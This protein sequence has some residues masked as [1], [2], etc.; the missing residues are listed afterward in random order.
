MYSLHKTNVAA[1]G[2]VR[3]GLST[4]LLSSSEIKQRITQSSRSAASRD[5]YV[6]ELV[7]TIINRFSNIEFLVLNLINTEDPQKLEEIVETIRFNTNTF[8]EDIADL[9]E[10]VPQLKELSG[11][12]EK[13]LD[14]L[15]SDKGI[16][17]GYFDNRQLEARL[18]SNLL[19]TS[20]LITD[21]DVA[22]SKIRQFGQQNMVDANEQLDTTIIYSSTATVIIVI[23]AMILT[24]V[25]SLFLARMIKSPLRV[26]LAKLDQM[27]RGDYGAP[28]SNEF[29]G[30][31]SEL[32]TSLNKLID[33]MRKIISDLTLAAKEMSQVSKSNQDGT[34][35]VKDRINAQNIQLSSGATAITQMEAAIAQVSQNMAHSLELTNSVDLDVERGQQMM[36]E[37]LST[38]NALDMKMG[39]SKNTV[40]EVSKMAPEMSSI[41]QVIDNVASKTNLL[42]LNAAIE[43]ARAGE[44]GRGFAVVAD[45]VRQL[46]LLTATS[47]E[48]IR[49]MIERLNESTLIASTSMEASYEQ[50]DNCKAITNKASTEMDSIRQNISA[51]KNNAQQIN[52][53]IVEQASTASVISKSV[54]K[55]NYVSDEN[56]QQ[57][58]VISDNSKLINHQMTVLEQIIK[59]FSIN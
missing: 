21:S 59:Q 48:K 50:L 27:V 39:E 13:F 30:E 2:E 15:V 18:Q 8:N 47:T 40:R 3:E 44:H 41:I 23:G 43:A 26:I 53:S 19:L 36:M 9:Q 17:A 24:I 11:E 55:I 6:S 56:A 58:S 46:A 25:I 33:A 10:E 35:V 20:K 28:I 22:L 49:N 4:L 51:I 52:D 5:I 34:K 42:A 12:T 1:S 31:F 37:N 32:A 7:T 14:A 45:E 38:I 16:I 54:N 29:S 57:I